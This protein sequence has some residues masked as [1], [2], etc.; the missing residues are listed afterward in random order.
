MAVKL[1][2]GGQALGWGA[3]Q[4]G[5]SFFASHPGVATE[6]ERVLSE[7]LPAGRMS[8]QA[9]VAAAIGDAADASLKGGV[10]IAVARGADVPLAMPRLDQAAR[11]GAAVIL[12][13]LGER[14]AGGEAAESS[15]QRQL[16]GLRPGTDSPI[17]VYVPASAA[18]CLTV[19]RA[20]ARAGRSRRA[21]AILYVDHILA[22]LREPVELDGEAPE[23]ET[24]LPRDIG[25]AE[26]YRTRD[27]SSLVIAGGIVARA[28]RTAVRVARE[29]GI[30]AGLCRLVQLWP[31]AE[32][33]LFEASAR[34]HTVLVAELN[35]GQIW[36]PV[37]ARL[38]GTPGRPRVRSLAE[39][40]A[41]TIP[42]ARILAAL[43]EGAEE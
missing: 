29:R 12:L 42:P 33:P 41:G 31:I 32:G 8:V 5:V 30:R 7:Q 15:T 6:I 20:A 21:P 35:E 1:L 22:H 2:L 43:E 11:A 24:P 25:P 28:A 3:L 19:A 10:S 18:E 9:D 34:A 13:V 17:R 4:G 26:L 23:D 36:E 14:G 37:A 38:Q 27:A 39:P 40:I 16:A